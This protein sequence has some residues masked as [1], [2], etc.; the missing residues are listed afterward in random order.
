MTGTTPWFLWGDRYENGA[1]DHGLHHVRL[2]DNIAPT[3]GQDKSTDII[4]GRRLRMRFIDGF[5]TEKNL[6][7]NAGA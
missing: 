1:E 4:G 6:Q 7:Y 2:V 5:S 3:Q